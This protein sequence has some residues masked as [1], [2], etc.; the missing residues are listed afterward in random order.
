MPKKPSLIAALL[1]TALWMG[2][3]AAGVLA[4]PASVS[5]EGADVQLLNT[6]ISADPVLAR[7]ELT[8]TAL[9]AV[10]GA[11]PVTN[12]T[13]NLTMPAGTGFVSVEGPGG[14][15]CNAPAQGANGNISCS[16]PTTAGTIINARA[17]IAVVS[18]P[19]ETP[20]GTLLSTTITA[21]ADEGDPNTAN[22]TRTLQTTV[23]GAG[24]QHVSVPGLGAGGLILLSLVLGMS[25]MMVIGRSRV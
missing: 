24:D 21:T 10:N 20:T 3:A 19:R 6:F 18:V 16:W 12:L 14:G 5:G 25:G 11:G 13:I 22:N 17:L 9:A 1:A 4:K 7:S 23:I 15:S 8:Y 2:P